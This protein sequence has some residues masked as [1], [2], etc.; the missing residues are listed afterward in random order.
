[1]TLRK[2]GMFM[3]VLT[4]L[5]LTAMAQDGAVLIPSGQLDTSIP[6]TDV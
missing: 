4:T 3:L 1:M 6:G 5:P 2:W